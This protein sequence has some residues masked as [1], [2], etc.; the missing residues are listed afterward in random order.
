MEDLHGDA[1]VTLK[2]AFD[3]IVSFE[4]VN[5]NLHLLPIHVLLNLRRNY[6]P[7]PIQISRCLG[8]ISGNI[9]VY[10]VQDFVS[11]SVK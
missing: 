4:N 9:A 11:Y 2:R 5:A 6:I 8:L 3:S 7:S 1:F 10:T